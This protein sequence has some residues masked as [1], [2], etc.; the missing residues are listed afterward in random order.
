MSI[1]NIVDATPIQENATVYQG[2][3]CYLSFQLGEGDSNSEY[4]F[5]PWDITGDTAIFKIISGKDGTVL[6]THDQT[7]GVTLAADG[8]LTAKVNDEDSANC[9]AGKHKMA[10]ILY[11]SNGDVF[12][13]FAG[14]YC[15]IEKLF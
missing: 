15:S 11:R 8:M 3:T 7:G 14:E 13:V 10:C 5:T 9:P 2:A 6:V 1:V 4:D 12:P